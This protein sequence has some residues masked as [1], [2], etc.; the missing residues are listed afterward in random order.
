[1]AGTRTRG[2]SW[3]ITIV[4][5]LLFVAVPINILTAVFSTGTTT[6]PQSALLTGASL[7]SILYLA[8]AY[9]LIRY[10]RWAWGLSL[11]VFALAFAGGVSALSAGKPGGAVNLVLAPLSGYLLLRDDTKSQFGY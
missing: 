6:V 11:A 2:V 3:Q 8:C 1:M 7:Y 4:A 5:A 10:Q 9:G